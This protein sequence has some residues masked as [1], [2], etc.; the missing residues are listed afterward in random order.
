M[1]PT[2]PPQPVET[3]RDDP[4]H[5]ANYQKW[6]PVTI[7][8]WDPDRAATWSG[9]ARRLAHYRV[10]RKIR[11][12]IDRLAELHRNEL[13]RADAVLSKEEAAVLL[14]MAQEVIPIMVADIAR[15]KGR[16]LDGFPILD[17]PRWQ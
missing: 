15:R 14:G 8:G 9:Y 17:D 13:M 3:I 16:P 1:L 12:M 6:L 11:N 10:H 7:P 5:V 4:F 2:A